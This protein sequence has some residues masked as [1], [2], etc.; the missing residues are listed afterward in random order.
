MGVPDDEKKDFTNFINQD[1]YKKEVLKKA[2][3]NIFN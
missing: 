3:N 2:K 1:V